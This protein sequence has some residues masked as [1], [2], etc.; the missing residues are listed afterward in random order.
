[1]SL[2]RVTAV[3]AATTH[4]SCDFEQ[5]TTHL[6]SLNLTNHA[7]TLGP[8]IITS[9]PNHL[10]N[11]LADFPLLAIVTR[12]RVVPFTGNWKGSIRWLI[13]MGFHGPHIENHCKISLEM[14]LIIMQLLS[15][16]TDFGVT[17]SKKKFISY[18]RNNYL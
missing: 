2:V 17:E 10:R 13:H 4:W 14:Y 3:P 11:L 16:T 1:M 15:H 12:G 5:Q 9:H 7:A 8:A 6:V 18:H